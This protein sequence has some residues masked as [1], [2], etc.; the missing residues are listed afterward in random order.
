MYILRY[1][2]PEDVPIVVGI[3]ALS[4]ATPWSDRS[5]IFEINDNPTAHMLILE[6]VQTGSLSQQPDA[7]MPKSG[8]IIGYSGMWLIDD[9][10]H[11]STIAIHPD[12]R[13]KGLGEILLIGML[14]R[15]II[16]HGTYAVLEVRVSN[17]PAIH[18]YQ[19]YE[20]EIVGQ[21]KHYYRDYNNEDALL[22]HLAPIDRAY[23]QRFHERVA[24]LRT[25][26]Q[27]LN[28]LVRPA[29]KESF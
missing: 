27:Y 14:S 5:Y 1:M 9:E 2:R 21:R 19:K 11:I 3:D 23:Q 22:M 15:T 16:L 28:L 18:L 26:V 24:A 7:P 13:G 6:S 12:Y 10:A 29:T 8:N 20:F 25:R 4:F 17:I